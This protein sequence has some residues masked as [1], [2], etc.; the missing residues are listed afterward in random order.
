MGKILK[1][2]KSKLSRTKKPIVLS[3]FNNNADPSMP[4]PGDI[5]SAM[6][7][8]NEKKFLK[9]KKM[10]SYATIKKTTPKQ[11]SEEFDAIKLLT[12]DWVKQG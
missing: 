3:D 5:S 2:I 6:I 12:S 11:I 7:M 9:F 1:S 10:K 8:T 4:I